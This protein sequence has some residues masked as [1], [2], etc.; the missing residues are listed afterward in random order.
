[1]WSVEPESDSNGR[2]ATPESTQAREEDQEALWVVDP[3]LAYY[4]C[5]PPAIWDDDDDDCQS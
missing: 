4:L 1:M 2:C 3:R 5:A